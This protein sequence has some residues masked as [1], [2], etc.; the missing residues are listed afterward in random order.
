MAASRPPPFTRA[1]VERVAGGVDFNFASTAVL[2]IEQ[3]SG[4]TN[5]ESDQK[6]KA[7]INVLLGK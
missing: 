4:W 1:L 6:A 7:R 2:R 3:F 5:W